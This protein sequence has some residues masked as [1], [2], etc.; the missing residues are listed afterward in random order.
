MPEP[1]ADAFSPQD[2][3]ARMAAVTHHNK[4]LRVRTEGITILLFA[5]CIMASY[6]TIAVPFLGG[7]GHGGGGDHGAFDR[8]DP[9]ANGSFNATARPERGPPPTQFFL[10]AYAP[11]AWYVVAALGTIGIWR[12]A[13]VSFPTGFSTPKLVALMVGWIALFVA[14]TVTLAFVRSSDPQA[15]HLIAWAV[16]LAL[17][18]AFNPMAFTP[19]GRAAVGVMALLAAAGAAYGFLANLDGRDLSFLTG[20][21]LGLPG[22]VAG[23]WLLYQG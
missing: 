9:V 15:W 4:G 18:V 8:L 17:F 11:L 22:V 19:K 13:A 1:D 7:G 12:S 10:S 5:V 2:A 6:L 20:M 21:A 23:L 16:V 3:L 14:M